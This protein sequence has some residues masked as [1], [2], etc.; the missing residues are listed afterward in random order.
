MVRTYADDLLIEAHAMSASCCAT[1]LASTAHVLQR[2]VGFKKIRLHTHEN[3]GFG[4]VNA[5]LV[6]K[7]YKEA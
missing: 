5:C 3:L 1:A 4:D 7:R 2:V 6:F